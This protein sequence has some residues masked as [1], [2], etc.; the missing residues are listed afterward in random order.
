MKAPP[1]EEQGRD[2]AEEAA[3]ELPAAVAATYDVDGCR[4]QGWPG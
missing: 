4:R 3:M 2:E 1:A